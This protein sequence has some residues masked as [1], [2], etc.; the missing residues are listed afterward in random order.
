QGGGSIGAPVASFTATS[1]SFVVPAGAASGPVT[2][3][4]ANSSAVSADS[5]SVV[6][7]SGFSVTV[8]PSSASVQQGTNTSYSVTLSS[9]NGFSQLAKLSVT[10]LPSGVTAAF[11]PAQITTGQI[12]I[13]TISAPAGQATGNATL[14]ISAAATVESI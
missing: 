4:A 14:T 10:G 11:S 2:V 6:A 3:T 13:L 1:I 7:S 9:S 8:G 12:A 5:L